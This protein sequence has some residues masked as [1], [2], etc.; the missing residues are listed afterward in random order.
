MNNRV[1]VLLALAVTLISGCQEQEEVR[2]PER[3]IKTVM[4]EHTGDWMNLPGVVGVAIAQLDDGTPCIR[5]F[6]TEITDEIR[7]A[8]PEVIEGHPVEIEVTGEFRRMDE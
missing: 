1:I 7:E 6:V 8:V 3:D 4:E 2:M 5:V